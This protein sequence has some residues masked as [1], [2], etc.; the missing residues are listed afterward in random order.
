D[1]AVDGGCWYKLLDQPAA[2][3]RL[4]Q[5]GEQFIY[6]PKGRDGRLGAVVHQHPLPTFSDEV[7][8]QAHVPCAGFEDDL[9]QVFQEFPQALRAV[10]LTA[11]QVGQEWR[12][13]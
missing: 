8:G 9:S 7:D 6:S 11:G 1:P 2:V 13:A 3:G 5:P 12:A 10:T 4:L